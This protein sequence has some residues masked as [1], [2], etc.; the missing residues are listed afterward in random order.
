MLLSFEM[1]DYRFD[2][3][4]GWYTNGMPFNH[5]NQEWST[6]WQPSMPN[7]NDE[8]PSLPYW[9]EP[10]ATH[11]LQDYEEEYLHPHQYQQQ[12]SYTDFLLNEILSTLRA[13]NVVDV[14]IEQQN[15][16]MEEDVR[17]LVEEGKDTLAHDCCELEVPDVESLTMVVDEDVELVHLSIEAEDEHLEIEELSSLVIQTT[18]TE[19]DNDYEAYVLN[20]QSNLDDI[21][22]EQTAT[23]DYNTPYYLF[24]PPVGKFEKKKSSEQ[25]QDLLEHQRLHLVPSGVLFGTKPPTLKKLFDFK[26][27]LSWGP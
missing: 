9:P 26:E 16:R 13:P 20:C 11:Y 14:E 4:Q 18:E 24:P 2:S 22:V 8:P 1:Q 23:I 21:G 7:W 27:L 17:E 3:N 5:Y 10:Q 25:N 12:E 19:V 15:Q 6:S